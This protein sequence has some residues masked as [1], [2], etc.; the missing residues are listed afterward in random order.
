[1]ALKSCAA[2]EKFKDQLSR[3]FFRPTLDLVGWGMQKAPPERGYWVNVSISSFGTLLLHNLLAVQGPPTD[4]ILLSLPF[5]SAFE[6]A[7]VGAGYDAIIS[8]EINWLP[9]H[10]LLRMSAQPGSPGAEYCADR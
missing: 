2:A 9:V 5:P 4:Q 1:M 6:P 8:T 10:I 3:D 7:K